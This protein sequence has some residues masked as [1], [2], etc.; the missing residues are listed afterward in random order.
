MSKT[1]NFRERNF[2]DKVRVHVV[3]GNGGNGCVSHF[4]S[5]IV[6]TGAPDGGNGGNGGDVLLKAS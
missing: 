5:R 3:G 4:R 1:A 2:V 6:Q